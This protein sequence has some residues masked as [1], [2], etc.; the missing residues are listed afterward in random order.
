MD[1]EDRGILGNLQATGD[2][3]RQVWERAVLFAMKNHSKAGVPVASWDW[4]E[5]EVVL[6]PA[7]DTPIPQ[8]PALANGL[9]TAHEFKH[10]S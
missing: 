6:T 4:D 5:G 2:D 9:G 3:V 8:E 1:D 7:D 10:T